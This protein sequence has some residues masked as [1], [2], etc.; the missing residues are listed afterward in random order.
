MEKA[1][2]IWDIVIVHC[3]VLFSA[4]ALGLHHGT[5]FCGNAPKMLETP[6]DSTAPGTTLEFSRQ[7]ANHLFFWV[8]V[9]IC[10]FFLF[11]KHSSNVWGFW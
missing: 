3:L 4:V 10:P 8:L 2:C 11:G 7:T 1:C 6:V 9:S 5:W